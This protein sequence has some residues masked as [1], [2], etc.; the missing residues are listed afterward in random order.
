MKLRGISQPG[1]QVNPPEANLNVQNFLTRLRKEL[2]NLKEAD[3]NPQKNNQQTILK[4]S[5]RAKV[6]TGPNLEMYG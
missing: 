6:P 1:W 4:A 2:I 5:G 3:S